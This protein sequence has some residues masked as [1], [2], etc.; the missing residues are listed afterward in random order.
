[1]NLQFTY[2]IVNVYLIS[3]YCSIVE[4][5]LKSNTSFTPNIKDQNS[6]KVKNKIQ[7]ENTQKIQ[8]Y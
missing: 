1:M 4:N 8:M 6:R 7:L 3:Y 5:N 2:Y